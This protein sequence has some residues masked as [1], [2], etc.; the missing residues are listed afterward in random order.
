[1]SKS[2]LV[3]TFEALSAAF[4]DL[5]IRWY[6]F[7]AQAA[8]FHGITRATADIDVTVEAGEH[9]TAE[10][11]T[12]LTSHG[13]VLRVADPAFVE[14]T[15][16]LPV[17]HATGIPVDVVLAGPGI[18]ELFLDRVVRRRVG[19]ADVPIAAAEDIIVMKVL[20]GRPKDVDDIRA[21]ITAKRDLDVARVRETL[22]L[23]ES[24]LDQSD[25]TP[26]FEAIWRGA[27][28]H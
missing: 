11:A 12:A 28:K 15:R 10:V 24:A 19:K 16:V 23:L 9:P 1:M 20:A 18:E 27:R 22:A 8:I 26:V 3:E 13:F 25:L 17:V 4:G 5:E 7:G 14:Q 6:V 2:K 21:I